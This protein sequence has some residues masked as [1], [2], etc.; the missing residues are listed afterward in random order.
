MSR[1]IVAAYHPIVVKGLCE[2]LSEKLAKSQVVATAT[3]VK[4]FLSLLK[5]HKP[6]TAVIDVSV[7][8]K[9]KIDLL[10]EIYQVY[11]NIKLHFVSVHPFDQGVQDYLINKMKRKIQELKKRKYT[12]FYPSPEN[13][14]QEATVDKTSRYEISR[15]NGQA[16]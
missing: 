8:W 2:A 13:Q 7:T 3:D 14:Y 5:I 15:V 4:S 1:I 11:P 12:P 10:D 16:V 9:S 6:D